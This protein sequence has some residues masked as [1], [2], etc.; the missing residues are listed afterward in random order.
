MLVTAWRTHLAFHLYSPKP[1][2]YPPRQAQ[3]KVKKK[4]SSEKR[5]HSTDWRVWI[6]ETLSFPVSKGVE[7]EYTIVEVRDIAFKLRRG[8]PCRGLTGADLRCQR[9]P[10]LIL[11]IRDWQPK[12]I[13]TALCSSHC[14][15]LANYGSQ[16]DRD[17]ALLPLTG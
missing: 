16:G 1:R 15:L 6:S 14:H 4:I 10:Q 11:R 7:Y 3:P 2:S 9:D 13:M 17:R 8:F 5:K 12:A